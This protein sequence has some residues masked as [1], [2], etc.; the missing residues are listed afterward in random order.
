MNTSTQIKHVISADNFS[1]IAGSPIAY[2]ASD[3]LLEVFEQAPLLSDIADPRQGLATGDNEKFLRFWHE[4]DDTKAE[5][6]CTKT[7][8]VK[9]NKKW[10]PCNKGGGYRKWYGNNERY[11]NWENDG[12]EMRHFKGSV[13]RNSTYYFTDGGTWSTLANAFSMRYSP[14]GFLFESKGS[15]CFSK[16]HNQL[17]YII[18]FLN[19][20][21]VEEVLLILSPT[22]DYHEGPLGRVPVI[23]NA[24]AKSEV[25]S[26]VESS[27]SLCKTDWDY[28]ETSWDFK[29]HP[30]I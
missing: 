6:S 19:S 23:V 1:K 29:K 17:L 30:L 12:F 21:I 11:V 15:V 5:R 20:C 13:I 8:A 4:V 18:G 9:S 24:D 2:W 10:F 28:F 3:V 25:D 22:L 27:I 16:K 14:E 26:L 7:I